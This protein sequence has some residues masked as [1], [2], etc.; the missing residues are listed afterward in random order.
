MI[1]I[2][3]YTESRECRSYEIKKE[4]AL[5]GRAEESDVRFNDTSVSRKHARIFRNGKDYFIKDLRGAAN[6]ASSAATE[7]YHVP[8]QRYEPELV[9]E[10]RYRINFTFFDLKKVCNHFYRLFR[11]IAINPL[12]LL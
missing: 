4:T 8:A 1:Q 2:H 11:E 6:M 10:R 5:V 9:I 12:S 7:R 3:V